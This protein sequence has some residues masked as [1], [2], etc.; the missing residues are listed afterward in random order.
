L[1]RAIEWISM[2]IGNLAAWGIPGAVLA[3]FAA[4]KE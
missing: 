2:R 3:E 1:A 4:L